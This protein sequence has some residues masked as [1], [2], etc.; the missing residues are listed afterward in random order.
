MRLCARLR[1]TN[2]TMATGSFE[3]VAIV[4]CIQHCLPCSAPRRFIVRRA[5]RR[6]A[7]LLG[8][9]PDPPLIGRRHRC[10]ALVLGCT[11][12]LDEQRCR[13]L[14]DL[15]ALEEIIDLLIG[16]TQR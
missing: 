4:I 1:R 12:A 16:Q 15:P 3:S 13:R 6:G 14:V 8:S 9:V 11:V 7:S 10:T 5:Q 2:M